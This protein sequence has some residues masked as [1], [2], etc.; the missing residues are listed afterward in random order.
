MVK[1]GGRADELSVAED[2]FWMFMRVTLIQVPAFMLVVC[3]FVRNCDCAISRICVYMHVFIS[4]LV[5]C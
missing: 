1:A 3:L 4:I 5:L 2:S